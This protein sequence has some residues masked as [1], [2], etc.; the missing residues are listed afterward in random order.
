[1]AKLSSSLRSPLIVH[2]NAC[3]FRQVI[4]QVLAIDYL[5][6]FK[7][8]HKSCYLMCNEANYKASHVHKS[9]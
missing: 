5:L 8:I 3:Y 1:M 6:E 9:S 2:K 4:D 7:H